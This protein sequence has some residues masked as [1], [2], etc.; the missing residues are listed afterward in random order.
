[1]WLLG[2]TAVLILFNKSVINGLKNTLAH[3]VSVGYQEI[4]VS[5]SSLLHPDGCVC[6]RIVCVC[7]CVCV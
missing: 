6:K 5:R 7:V 2:R 3:P 1:M 4:D